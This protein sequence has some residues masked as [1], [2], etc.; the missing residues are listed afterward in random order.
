LNHNIGMGE[1][2]EEVIKIIDWNLAL[3]ITYFDKMN[4]N[5]DI[6]LNYKTI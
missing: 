1:G 5:V 6:M 4:N 3:M 2:G